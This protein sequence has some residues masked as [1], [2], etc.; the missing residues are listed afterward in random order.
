MAYL[1]VALTKRGYGV[2]TA[3][4][5]AVARDHLAGGRI[6]KFD[7]VIT[8]YRMPGNTGLDLLRWIQAEDPA[9]ATIIVTAEGEKELV[10]A[11]FR[12]GAVDFLEKPVALQ[13]LQAAVARAVERT[14]RQ[15]HLN[16]SEAAIKEL[17]EQLRQAQKMEA[18]GQLAGGVAHD[19]N[20]MLAAVLLHLGMLQCNPAVTDEMSESLKEMEKGLI[21]ATSLTRQLLLFSRR[22]VPRVET[23]RLN[24]LIA[25][26]LNMLRRL[27][28]ENIEVSYEEAPSECWLEADAG[29]I[30][31]VLM[32]LCINA[33]DAMTGGGRLTIGTTL[34]DLEAKPALPNPDFRPGR[35]IRLSVTDTGCGMD[36]KVLQ[37]IFEPFFTTKEVGKGTG[38][39]L[40]TVYG[41]VKQHNGWVEVDSVVGRGSAFH[42]YL[43]ASRREV[44]LTRASEQSPEIRGGQET[45][46]LVEDEVSVRRAAALCLRKLGYAV[47]EAA[48]GMQALHV[49]ERQLDK[50]DLLLT[51]MVMPEG[52]TGL[53]LAESLK[54]DKDGLKVI[55]SSGYSKE[56]TNYRPGNGAHITYLAKPYPAATLAKTVRDCLDRRPATAGVA[57]A[58]VVASPC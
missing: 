52:M 2:A 34:L 9:L 36:E 30:E 10:A 55:I 54:K 13:D 26:L 11:S 43:P 44:C 46:L 25:D 41:I 16:R 3:D 17:G 35:F 1:Q 40:A 18:I 57:E 15:R 5:A 8:D 23:L 51:D 12:N 4:S 22:Q 21:R 50:I 37:R 32:N 47:L 27:L 49:W 39:G 53:E 14:E 7:C 33:R 48:D 29:M 20:N 58:E 42:V 56:A 38:L 45:I 28:G 24:G 19:F 6:H 31:Q